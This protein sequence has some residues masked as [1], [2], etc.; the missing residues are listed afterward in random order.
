MNIDRLKKHL[1][2][3]E[4]K[5]PH[6]YTDSEGYLTIG[7]GRLIDRRKDGKLSEDEMNYLLDNDIH[8]HTGD[9]ISAHPE[10]QSLDEVRQ[11]VLVNMCF[12]LGIGKLNEFRKM[13][14]YINADDFKAAADEML[15]S[16]WATQVGLRAT[17]LSAAMRTGRF[18]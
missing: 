6:A 5:V 4:G 16:K 12:N 18:E 10:V 2:R 8:R 15:D 3:D 7:V 9:L 17:R 14:G 11:E 13:W 1:T